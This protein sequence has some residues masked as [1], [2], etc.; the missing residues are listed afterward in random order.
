MASQTRLFHGAFIATMLSLVWAQ[1][2]PSSS[3]F[4]DARNRA[5]SSFNR[6]ALIIGLVVGIGALLSVGALIW[7]F[8]RLKKQKEWQRNYVREAQARAAA[9]QPPQYTPADPAGNPGNPYVPGV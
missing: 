5:R 4:D 3:D 7:A 1:S 2:P 8:R 9:Q 6:A